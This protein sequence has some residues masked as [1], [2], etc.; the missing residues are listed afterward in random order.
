M[1]HKRVAWTSALVCLC[2]ALAAWAAG[3]RLST[4]PSSVTQRA[5]EDPAPELASH[6]IPLP[7]DAARDDVTG[8]SAPRMTRVTI[9]DAD[10]N[11]IEATARYSDGTTKVRGHGLLRS[12]TGL[13]TFEATGYESASAVI[14]DSPVEITMRRTWSLRGRAYDAATGDPVVGA[15]FSVRSADTNAEIGREESLAD[16]S[17]LIE[18]IPS[19]RISLFGEASGYIPLCDSPGARFPGMVLDVS[20]DLAVEAPLLPILVAAIKL[21]NNTRRFRNSCG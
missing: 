4:T 13:T 18:G 10:G 12:D 21:H 17:F 7:V 8:D 6:E 2:V 1:T 3:F 16:G 9:H 14:G 19:G 5:P 15:S 20:D 11:L